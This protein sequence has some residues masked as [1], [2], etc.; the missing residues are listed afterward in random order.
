VGTFRKIETTFKH[1]ELK[2]ARGAAAGCDLLML[3]FND[4]IKRSSDRGPSL[5]QLLHWQL[6]CVGLRLLKRRTASFIQRPVDS[7]PARSTKQ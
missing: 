2:Y 6:Q 3:V 5:R 1:P 7:R 4:K